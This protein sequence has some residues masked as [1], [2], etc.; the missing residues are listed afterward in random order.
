LVI[1]PA[2]ASGEQRIARR[3][4]SRLRRRDA[5]V[6]AVEVVVGN[7]PP[8]ILAGV[9][10]LDRK[11]RRAVRGPHAGDRGGRQEVDRRDPGA[12]TA[13]PEDRLEAVGEL[14]D[15]LIEAPAEAVERC[16]RGRRGQDEGA[17]YGHADEQAAGP[18]VRPRQRARVAQPVAQPGGSLVERMQPGQEEQGREAEPDQDPQLL[19]AGDAHV[20]DQGEAGDHHRVER[21]MVMEDG[22]RGELAGAPAQ[23]PEDQHEMAVLLCEGQAA[24]GEIQ[25]GVDRRRSCREE[26]RARREVALEQDPA[27]G[28]RQEQRRED[29]PEQV[30]DPA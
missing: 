1:A 3:Y 13:A 11:D 14:D 7:R 23:D 20:Q 18:Q 6:L 24:E 17:E 10:H 12:G 4:R 25:V 15:L 16:R 22:I 27:D 26:R 19:I 5:P 21:A 29:G 8:V 28:D 9:G 30:G 2:N